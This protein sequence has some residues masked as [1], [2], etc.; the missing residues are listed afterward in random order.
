MGTIQSSQIPEPTHETFRAERMFFETF[1]LRVLKHY[2]AQ[3]HE[4]D[5]TFVPEYG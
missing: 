2:R 3:G 5:M 1:W 4:N